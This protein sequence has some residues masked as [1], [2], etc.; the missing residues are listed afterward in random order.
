MEQIFYVPE[1]AVNPI[2]PVDESRHCVSVLRQKQGDRISVTDGLG[3]LFT[4]I[5]EDANPKRCR[6]QIIERTVRK[7]DWNYEIE[8]AVAPTK[9][10]DRMEWFVEKATE[11]G[12]NR[13]RFVRCKQSE[14][15]EIKLERL[16]KVAV[17]AM[18]QSQKTVLPQIIEMTGFNDVINHSTAAC[19]MIA[20]CAGDDRRLMGDVYETGANALILIGPE[21]DFSRDE[22]DGAI[23]KG[24]QP[25]SLGGSRL[26]TETAA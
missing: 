22:I 12:I 3:N 9:S 10:I 14:R 5:L 21:G 15:R 13:I 26:R 17:S 1:I 4:A 18:K 20:H 23:A 24:F 7:P 8:I 16:V 11:V 25:V 6:L 2:L 19:R